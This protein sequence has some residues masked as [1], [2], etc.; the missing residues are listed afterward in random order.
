MK[1]HYLGVDIG[2][3]FIKYAKVDEEF[4]IINK[5]KVKSVEF[6]DKD[7][8]YDYLCSNMGDLHEVESI[9]ISAP[10]LI[11]KESNVKS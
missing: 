3:T 9:G 8:F 1:K 6:A 10:G 2:G 7:G 11:D 4:N 5:W